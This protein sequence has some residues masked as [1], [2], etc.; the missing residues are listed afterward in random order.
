VSSL[1]EPRRQPIDSESPSHGL[2]LVANK[3]SQT[4]GIVDPEAGREVAEIAEGGIT[5]H[6]VAASPEGQTETC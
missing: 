2:R 1:G 5:G 3:G 6:Q 4:L